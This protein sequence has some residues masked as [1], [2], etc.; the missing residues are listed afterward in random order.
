MKEEE[1][2]ETS[3]FSL[4]LKSEVNRISKFLKAI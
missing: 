3:L 4:H 1:E 2:E